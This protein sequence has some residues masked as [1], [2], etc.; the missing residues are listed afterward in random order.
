MIEKHEKLVHDEKCVEVIMQ[1]GRANER[2]I[3]DREWE[4]RIWVIEES[5]IRMIFLLL[6]PHPTYDGSNIKKVGY[7]V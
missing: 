5:K 7:D 1:K 2:K 3:Y 4:W 6:L